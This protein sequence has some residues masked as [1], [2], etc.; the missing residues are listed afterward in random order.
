MESVYCLFTSVT[1]SRFV[2]N[3]GF[4]YCLL[5]ALFSMVD[6]RI[7]QA[8]SLSCELFFKLFLQIITWQINHLTLSYKNC[9]CLTDEIHQVF[10]TW[11]KL[12]LI[13]AHF[14]CETGH[15]GQ[16]SRWSR[17][18]VWRHY[19]GDQWGKHGWHAEYRGPEQDQELQDTA[20]SGSGEVTSSRL[21]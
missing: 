20:T 16:Q 1:F 17:P 14:Y 2:K 3:S 12:D 11:D 21:H 5:G 6:S 19:L 4:C 9:L 18:A 10:R 15:W 13:V 7:G 8:R